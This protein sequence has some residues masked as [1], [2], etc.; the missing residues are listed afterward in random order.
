MK[1]SVNMKLLIDTNVILD[2]LLKREEFYKTAF[3]ILKRANSSDYICYV[4]ASA[5]TDIYYISFKHFKNH[6][7]VMEM[8]K[9]LFKIIKICAVDESDISSAI[10]LGWKNFEDAVQYC[11]AYYNK[12]NYIVTRN[13][14][15][16]THCEIPVLTP[17]EALKL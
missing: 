16:Y 12:L 5:I 14:K 1:D 6:Q 17:E 2:V 10:N 11:S 7:T 15:D 4:S 13:K 9:N 8:L 3:E